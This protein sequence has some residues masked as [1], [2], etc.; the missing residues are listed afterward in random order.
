MLNKQPQYHLQCDQTLRQNIHANLKNFAVQSQ[1]SNHAKQAAVAITI[2]D[3]G[4]GAGIY[5]LPTFEY[6]RE[7]AA[8]ILTRRSSRLKN[9][10]GQ[11]AFPG[12]HMD[13]NETPEDAALRELDEEVGLKLPH[14]GILGRLDDFYTRS[15]FVITPVVVWGGIVDTLEPDP[16][17]VQAIHR[18]PMKEFL[19]TD[20]PILEENSY[21]KHP[22]LLM[23]VGNNCIAAPTAAL[24]YQFREVA[25]RGRTTRVAH[26]EQPLFAWK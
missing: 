3:A 24:I 17:E 16:A 1:G 11:W 23:P 12:G 21:G 25:V 8:L 18:I 9:H 15:G 6:P 4:L 14:T 7:E 22:V 26:F 10:A 2:V 5:G 19:R 20:A 13:K